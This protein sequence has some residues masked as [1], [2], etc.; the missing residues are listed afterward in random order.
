MHSDF[1]RYRATESHRGSAESVN[2]KVTLL[3]I[4]DNFKLRG[5]F[6]TVDVANNAR[7]VYFLPFTQL[8]Y[9]GDN[10]CDFRFAILTPGPF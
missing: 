4:C 6:Q 8:L 10:F 7:L 3:Y 1:K 5:S 2:V 9:K